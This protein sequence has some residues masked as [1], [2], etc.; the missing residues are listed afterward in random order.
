VNTLGIYAVFVLLM[1]TALTGHDLR[2]LRLRLSRNS[3]SDQQQWAAAFA[4]T[5]LS[6][7]ALRLLAFA[8]A[9]AQNAH[10]PPSFNPGEGRREILRFYWDS[11]VR[12]QFATVLAALFTVGVAAWIQNK[13]PGSNLGTGLPLEWTLAIISAVLLLGALSW[14]II[15]STAEKLIDALGSLVFES[16]GALAESVPETNAADGA[17]L[18]LAEHILTLLEQNRQVFWEASARI[19][20]STDRLATIIERRSETDSARNG[21]DSTELSEMKTAIDRLTTTISGL[22]IGRADA[23]SLRPAPRPPENIGRDIRALLKQFE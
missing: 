22:P 15:G 12:V 9:F 7:L 19:I 3:T 1:T 16:R 21:L 2:R 4:G 14:I 23:E 17:S 8:P 18:G 5:D 10:R 20:E 11:L 13:A 6:R